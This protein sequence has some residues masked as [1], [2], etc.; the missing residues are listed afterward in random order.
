[1]INCL[2]IGMYQSRHEYPSLSIMITDNP[3][4]HQG[5]LCFDNVEEAVSKIQ[6]WLQ[7]HFRPTAA[8]GTERRRA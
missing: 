3:R 5:R 7:A 1:M 4:Y 2:K 8:S 6:G